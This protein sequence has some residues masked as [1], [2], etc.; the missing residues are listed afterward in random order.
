MESP[1]SIMMHHGFRSKEVR[2]AR[3][4]NIDYT[5]QHHTPHCWLH[6]KVMYPANS[7][8]RFSWLTRSNPIL[9]TKNVQTCGECDTKCYPNVYYIL[10]YIFYII[11]LPM[12]GMC[13]R[14]MCRGE[15]MCMRGVMCRRGAMLHKMLS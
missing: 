12:K 2:R 11:I 5:K 14:V 9:L 6:A 10:L 8:K 3:K 7:T 1:C 15:G 13:R 4:Q